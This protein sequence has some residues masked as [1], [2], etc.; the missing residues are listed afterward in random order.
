[1][2]DRDTTKQQKKHRTR[3]GGAPSGKLKQKHDDRK[4]LFSSS[5]IHV[6]DSFTPLK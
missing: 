6:G 1:M 5:E 3:G 4:V 2:E